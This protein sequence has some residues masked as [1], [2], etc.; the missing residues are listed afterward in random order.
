MAKQQEESVCVGNKR[1][2]NG[3]R[4]WPRR[5]CPAETPRRSP[6]CNGGALASG[7]NS[8]E[9]M[10]AARQRQLDEAEGQARRG[11]AETENTPQPTVEPAAAFA[12]R[13]P[14][15]ANK[16]PSNIGRRMADLE[17]SR[18]TVQR[19]ADHVGSLPR[20]RLGQ[21]RAELGHMPPRNPG[22]PPGDGGTL[23]TAS[24]RRCRRPHSLNRWAASA[25]SWP[26]NIARPMRS[27]SDQRKELETIRQQLVRQHETGGRARNGGSIVGPPAAKRN[28][29]AGLPG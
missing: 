6:H 18:Q 10:L 22:N 11:Q 17:R 14:R 24:R 19:R 9:N 5:S 27:W 4:D 20:G 29:A 28:A 2:R 13:L 16:W 25:R 26:T 8:S 3:W 7:E 21:L 1:W 23:G 15:Y 12:E